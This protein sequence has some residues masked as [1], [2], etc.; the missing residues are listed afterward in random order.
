[1]NLFPMADA[2]ENHRVLPSRRSRAGVADSSHAKPRAGNQARPSWR[3]ETGSPWARWAATPRRWSGGPSDGTTRSARRFLAVPARPPRRTWFRTMSRRVGRSPCA[4][5]AER[6][7]HQAR[8]LEPPLHVAAR[9]GTER[10]GFGP[11]AKRLSLTDTSSPRGF[12]GRGRRRPDWLDSL[13]PDQ[14][15]ATRRRGRSGFCGRPHL[16]A[17]AISEPRQKAPW[18]PASRR[19]PV[20]IFV[21]QDGRLRPR[22]ALPLFVVST[23]PMR[24]GVTRFEIAPE[25]DAATRDAGG[26]VLQSHGDDEHGALTTLGHAPKVP[27]GRRKLKA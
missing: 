20:L 26:R 22:L 21:P 24:S 11:R 25:L 5:P 6:P 17:H 7:R 9:K 12:R 13:E 8:A 14:D 2:R 23:V 1:M 27:N 16:G 10:S 18:R 4:L 3:Q 19:L 15:L